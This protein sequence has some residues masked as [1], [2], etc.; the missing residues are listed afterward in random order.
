MT[1][2]KRTTSAQEQETFPTTD[3]KALELPPPPPKTDPLGLD[4]TPPAE[5]EPVIE[6]I[7]FCGIKDVFDPSP[8]SECSTICKVDCLQDFNEC[9]KHHQN[10]PKPTRKRTNK[11]KDSDTTKP[12]KEKK[13][14]LGKSFWGHVKGTQAGL[15]DDCL[16]NADRPLALDEI[17]ACANTDRFARVL[18]HIKWVQESRMAMF[19]PDGTIWFNQDGYIHFDG[20]TVAHEQ[21]EGVLKPIAEYFTRDFYKA[22]LERK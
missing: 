16:I 10:T 3:E 8:K 6:F 15:I 17:V 14:T 5:E 13:P 2:K 18:A 12:T 19:C 1:T 11:P 20:N 7:P 21:S 22:K 9:L 4:I